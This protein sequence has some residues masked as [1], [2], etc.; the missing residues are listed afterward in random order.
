M[1]L[2]EL[3]DVLSKLPQFHDDNLLVGINTA[4]DAGVYKL[5]DE[6]A[7]ILTVDF[8]TPI[9]DDPY[10]YGQIAAANSLS[11]VYAMG[12]KPVAALNIVGFHQKFFSLDVLV[13]ILK[14]GAEKAAEANT[15]IAGGHTIMD[16]ELKYGLSVTGIIHPNKI[17]TNAAAK[18]GDKLVLT[19]PL[20]TGI[21]STA[22]K[23]GKDLGELMTRATNV[24]ATLNKTAAEVMQEIGVNA[25]T[26][27]TGFGLL[28]HAYE[29][30]AGS[31]VGFKIWQ[32]KVPIF[33]D[34]ISLIKAGF[35]PGGT[36]NNR[37]YLQDK[38]ILADSIDWEHST[39]LFDAQTSGGL[40]I[41]VAESKV[42]RLIAELRTRNVETIAIVG[43]VVADHPGKIEVLV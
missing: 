18:P 27:I 8:F 20:G 39:L 37:Y 32:S 40:F 10:T 13:E 15:V 42:D 35:V 6:I 11:D 38:V 25:C 19:K 30:A 14:G 31:K 34:A 16:E 43:E 22:L 1:S 29:M 12:G 41:S 2:T 9:V 24:M 28:G 33:E 5:T 21:I 23:S 26:D 36:S 3:G 7:L 17:V 4:D